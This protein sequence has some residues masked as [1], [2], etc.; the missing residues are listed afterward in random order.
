ME[1][2][3]NMPKK[4]TKVLTPELRQEF[5]QKRITDGDI[6]DIL[7]KLKKGATIWEITE[8]FWNFPFDHNDRRTWIFYQR[9][10][11]IRHQY[12]VPTVKLSVSLETKLA[13]NQFIA[14]YGEKP[15]VKLL[16]TNLKRTK[17]QSES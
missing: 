7:D 2:T 4:E 5:L 9:V 13:V 16:K 6:P 1:E 17:K 12:R 14:Q 11:Q 8:D 10:N 3:K 15:L